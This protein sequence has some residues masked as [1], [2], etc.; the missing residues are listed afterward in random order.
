MS[1]LEENHPYLYLEFIP[2]LILYS[3]AYHFII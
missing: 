1:Q 3:H 2:L